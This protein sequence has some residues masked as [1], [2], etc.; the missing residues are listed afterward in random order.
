MSPTGTSDSVRLCVRA[1][2]CAR[3]RRCAGWPLGGTGPT[4]PTAAVSRP[5]PD[6]S[7]PFLVCRARHLLQSMAFLTLKVRSS[8]REIKFHGWLIHLPSQSDSL[9]L[10]LGPGG[11][12]SASK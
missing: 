2:L 12:K 5:R 6:P 3:V 9:L 11:R 1:K 10:S 7:R 4:F 8:N